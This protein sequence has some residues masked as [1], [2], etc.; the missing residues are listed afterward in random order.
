MSRF[1]RKEAFAN[2]MGLIPSDY[3]SGEQERRGH[4]T[5]QRN[6][7]VRSWL[8]EASW[9]AIQYDP[10]LLE[11]FR[12]VFSHSGSKKK[13]IVAVARKLAMRLRRLLLDK[14]PYEVGIV[15]CR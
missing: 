5:K 15:S 4:I 2:F 3:S 14:K 13:A 6:R 7:W 9:R 11:K 12:R 8:V 10:V 1:Q